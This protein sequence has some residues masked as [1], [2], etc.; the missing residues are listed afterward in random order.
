MKSFLKKHGENATDEKFLV[1]IAKEVYSYI[2]PM[3][4]K[5]F[6]KTLIFGERYPG[7]A[8]P[9]AVLKE[10]LPYIDVISV[11]P[12]NVNFPKSEF[13]KLYSTHGKPIMIC[14]HQV[15]F[16]TEKHKVVMWQTLPSVTAVGK[17]HE[18]YLKEG[19]STPY[20]IGYHRCQYIDRLQH[21]RGKDILKQ[22]LL[23]SDGKPIRAWW[24]L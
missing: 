15:S 7:R 3:T 22:G 23:Q 24:S 18:L 20:L 12:G 4:K 21:K 17:A 11:Q 10:A 8:L 9:L 14:D 6:P 1:E 2:G 19:F 13:N 5:H 16:K